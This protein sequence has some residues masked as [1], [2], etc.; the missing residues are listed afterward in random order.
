MSLEREIRAGRLLIAAALV[1][2]LTLH[3]CEAEAQSCRSRAGGCLCSLSGSEHTDFA[4]TGCYLFVPPGHDSSAPAP[5]VVA[6]H[7]DGGPTAPAHILAALEVDAAEQGVLVFAPRVP[8]GSSWR[9]WGRSSGYDPD[10]LTDRI[11]DVAAEHAVDPTRIY[12]VGQSGG[13]TFLGWYAP[14]HADWFAGVAYFAGGEGYCSSSSFARGDYCGETTC[15]AC[16]MRADLFFGSEDGVYP[17]SSVDRLDAYFH[18]ECGEAGAYE[19]LDGAGHSDVACEAQTRGLI[20]SML[21]SW[22]ASPHGCGGAPLDTGGGGP[23]GTD[24]GPEP[25]ATPDAGPGGG[26]A[27]PDA[28]PRGDG[29]PGIAGHDAT[30]GGKDASPGHGS[31][32]APGSGLH[33]G[34]AAGGRGPAGPAALW[35]VWLAVLGA[36]TARRT[37]ATP[38]RGSPTPRPSPSPDRPPRA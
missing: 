1:A 16:P 30:I 19:V 34:C 18:D 25:P 26:D 27:G 10:W 37:R 35:L 4:C 32:A 14:T 24:A 36:I 8:S 17:R 38:E 11:R 3:A 21:S 33:G 12:L 2:G 9:T 29:G 13:S 5:L 15:P 28:R 22:L 7:G 23:E 20:A 6:F 31:G